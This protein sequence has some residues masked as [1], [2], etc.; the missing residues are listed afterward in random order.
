MPLLS[1]S[2]PPIDTASLTQR[3][4]ASDNPHV[5]LVRERLLAAARAWWAP[6]GPS[7]GTPAP[8]AWRPVARLDAFGVRGAVRRGWLPLRQH[9]RFPISGGVRDGPPTVRPED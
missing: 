3:P 4:G 9:G 8:T 2:D 1:P 7:G 5:L 6:P